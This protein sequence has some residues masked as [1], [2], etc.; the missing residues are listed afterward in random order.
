MTVVSTI[1]LWLVE[2]ASVGTLAFSVVPTLML[3][4]GVITGAFVPEVLPG[5]MVISFSIVAAL[6]A[7][8]RGPLVALLVAGNMV[9]G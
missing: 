7:T 6:V 5:A 9:W 2:G 3:P 1:D 4:D 8:T